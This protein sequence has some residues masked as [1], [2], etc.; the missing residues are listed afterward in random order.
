VKILLKT[1]KE[2]A[3]KLKIVSNCGQ[4]SPKTIFF[5]EVLGN[6]FLRTQENQ[7]VCVC[8]FFPGKSDVTFVGNNI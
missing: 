5:L 6:V 1:G 8:V 7:Y 2:T 3:Q 4:I